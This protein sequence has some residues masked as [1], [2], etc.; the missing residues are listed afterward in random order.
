MKRLKFY[1]VKL[2]QEIIQYE[3]EFFNSSKI[4][5]AKKLSFFH[6]SLSFIVG[7]ITGV[8]GSALVQFFPRIFKFLLK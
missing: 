8:I 6:F 7:I 3:N 4:Q 5:W 2:R 1:I